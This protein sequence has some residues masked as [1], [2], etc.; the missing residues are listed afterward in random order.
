MMSNVS[1]DRYER[2]HPLG[3]VSRES[4]ISRG[5]KRVREV[6]CEER[7]RA[8]V[9]SRRDPRLVPSVLKQ[10]GGPY[11]SKRAGQEQGATVPLVLG[12]APRRGAVSRLAGPLFR[13]S[14]VDK[15]AS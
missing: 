10:R 8:G 15:C 5:G 12:A 14:R 6:V 13:P 4:S 9:H 2:A 3:A 11:A 7:Q 1:A